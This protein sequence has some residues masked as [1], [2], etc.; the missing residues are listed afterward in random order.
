MPFPS[1]AETG[2]T[3]AASSPM[4]SSISSATRSGWAEGRSTLFTTGMISRPASSARY[5]FASVCAS[6]PCAASTTRTA[7]SHACSALETS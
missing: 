1:L 7:P 2:R 3:S 6:M 5:A 4:I